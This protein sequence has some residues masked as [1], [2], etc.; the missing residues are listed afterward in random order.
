MLTSFGCMRLAS[1]MVPRFVS[2][3][4][5]FPRTETQRIQKFALRERGSEGCFDRE[6]AS[7]A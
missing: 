5:E 7:S 4:E 3:V 6:S 2:I 1:F